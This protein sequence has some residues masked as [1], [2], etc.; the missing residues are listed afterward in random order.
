MVASPGRRS[1]AAAAASA[2]AGR[3]PGRVPAPGG[4]GPAPGEWGEALQ[5]GDSI[6]ACT[7]KGGQKLLTVRFMVV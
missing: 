1:R 6:Q 2:R 3:A 5:R 4:R 7:P